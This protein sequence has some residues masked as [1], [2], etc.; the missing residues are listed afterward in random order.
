MW[1][2]RA[3]EAKNVFSCETHIHKW[4]RMQGMKP[5]DSQARSHYRNPNIGF[6]TKCELQGPMRPKMCLGMKCTSSELPGKRS[7]V[8]KPSSL[9]KKSRTTIPTRTLFSS[10]PNAPFEFQLAF[11]PRF[12]LQQ[13]H[14]QLWGKPIL[15][16]Q[17]S[18]VNTPPRGFS[19]GS[20][21]RLRMWLQPLQGHQN[22]FWYTPKFSTLPVIVHLLLPL[23]V[24][25]AKSVGEVSMVFH[26]AIPDK[27]TI[28]EGKMRT[29]QK[30]I[31]LHR[32]YQQLKDTQQ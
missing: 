17:V 8:E 4:G 13:L 22:F 10:M 5:N 24:P 15:L 21:M 6:M 27:T 1:S 16:N 14:G 11:P 28:E 7:L 32:W 23:L 12:I 20:Q 31:D 2:A 19:S 30:F 29:E 18:N 9:K 3:H 25:L 26:A